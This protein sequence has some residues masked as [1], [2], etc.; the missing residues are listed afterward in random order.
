MEFVAHHP[1][2]ISEML[3][4]RGSKV[5]YA[6]KRLHR[7][8]RLY[9]N[10]E[11]V[12]LALTLVLTLVGG[13]VHAR[14]ESTGT[15]Y[16]A[17]QT[18]DGLIDNSVTAVSQSPDG[19]LWVGTEGGLMRFNGSDFTEIS[20]RRIKGVQSR[21]VRCLLFDRHGNLW[22]GMERGPIVRLGRHGSRV[23]SERDGLFARQPLSIAEDAA[24]S[25][26][27]AYPNEI[28]RILDDAV[29]RFTYQE[30]L[31]QGGAIRLASDAE[32]NIW[33]AKGGRVATYF[34]GGIQ[35]VLNFETENVCL[36]SGAEEGLWI[37]VGSRI[38]KF[39]KGSTPVEI[40]RMP[41]GLTASVV[42]ED[43]DGLL[44]IG[45]AAGGMFRLKDG[46]LE[47]VPLSNPTVASISQDREGNIWV[48]T[49]GGGMDL[50][51]TRAMKLVN[52]QDGLPF[53][54]VRSVCQDSEGGIWATGQNGDLAIKRNGS[55]SVVPSGGGLATCVAADL[56]EGVWVGTQNRGLWHFGNEGREKRAS[57]GLGSAYIRSILPATNGDL[58]VA[59][60]SPFRLHRMHDGEWTQMQSDRDLGAIAAMAEGADGTIWV[61]TGEGRILRVSGDTLV[62]EPSI[63][64]S[65]PFSIRS[66][67]A[68]PDGS[69]WIGYAGDGL[70]WFKE[71]AY[72]RITTAEGLM[73]DYISQML[74]DGHGALWIAANRGIFQVELAEL[75]AVAEGRTKWVRSRVYGLSEGLPSLQPNRDYFPSAARSVDGNLWF[76][77]RDGLVL[78]QPEKMRD[79]REP[80]MV[81]LERVT[82]DD[83]PAALYGNR[84]IVKRAGLGQLLDLSKPDAV[85][86]VP[87]DNRKL[88][89][90][91]AAL[92]FA[93][94]ENVRF[95][96]RLQNF[97]Q[98]WIEADTQHSATY[99]Q[100]PAGKYEFH[101]VACNNA[102]VWNMEG[103][104]MKLVVAPFFWDTWWFKVGGGLATVILA[105]GAVYLSQRGRHRRQLAR[106][107][108]KRA[109][110]Q[111]RARIARDIHDDLGASVTRIM[112]LSRPSPGG[113]PTSDDVLMPQI[114]ST[115]RNLIRSMGEVVWAV[116][117]EQDSFEGLADYFS[118]YAQEFLGVAGLRCRLEMPL[119][120]PER[121]LS[122][123][124]RHG[125]FLA[126]KE[127][128]NNIVKHS[129]ATEV[130]ISLTPGETSLV[131]LIEDNG[132]GL[133]TES[134]DT[135]GSGHG[136]VNM[137]KRL[138]DI[139]GSCEVRSDPSKGTAVK[140][141]IQL[142]GKLEP[143]RKTL[144]RPRQLP[145]HGHHT[146]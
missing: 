39:K 85:L 42:F 145:N 101:V 58:W 143:H 47:Q 74:D 110:E 68:A 36:G 98:D 111:E 96:Y 69:L 7:S 87:P 43:R 81:L 70:G 10:L 95:R 78:A 5:G 3:I 13:T 14:A 34:E 23:F 134:G 93:S 104:T 86:Q 28:Y 133:D 18:A 53:N 6:S 123:K 77:T 80:P 107:V 83:Q 25:I 67:Y 27:V 51:R 90:E 56:R 135:G 59:T 105:G 102:G 32:G 129:E 30:G 71:G 139:G 2:E 37:T 61:G 44:W 106:I 132:K 122:A 103:I 109:L 92:S 130:R 118:N 117:P 82:M 64:E 49:N 63:M 19:Y 108:A 127:G 97:D 50:I 88:K 48:G 79:N 113:I 65:V 76:S 124:V 22:V 9:G 136:L 46:L 115:S 137:V 17:F 89:F 94:P 138:E 146:P 11:R 26:W 112:L 52:R 21:G 142:S 54:S 57:D 141:E 16:R 120:L 4:G 99:P 125:L 75:L 116:N 131:L 45:M 31:P 66:L 33:I 72:A 20:L 24:G 35:S 100:L 15:F 128:L 140:F 40:G 126:F 91:F 60:D 1:D 84:E 12:I 41:D 38:L 144:L 121:I 29:T 55:W 114:Y 73:D 8:M 62:S 119:N